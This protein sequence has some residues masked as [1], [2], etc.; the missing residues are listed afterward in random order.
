MNYFKKRKQLKKDIA[1]YA[2]TENGKTNYA[3]YVMTKQESFFYTIVGVLLFGLL[4][5]TFY[6]SIIAVA[7]TGVFG[8][9]FPDYMYKLLLNKRKANLNMQFKDLLY[10]I[11]SSLS[12]GRSVE[13]AFMEAP[14]DLEMLYPNP[15][16][17]IIKEL[18]YINSG[19]RLNETI[20]SLLYD[21]SQR[22]GDEDIKS[23]AD[24]F[25]SC[26][27]TGGNLIEV[28]RITSN[29]ISDKIEIKK[30]IASGLVEKKFEQKGMCALMLLVILGLSYM[31]G[32]YMDP[33]FT[34]VQGRIAMTFALLL[35]IASYFVG[36]R[37]TNIQ[38]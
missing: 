23:F 21:F 31:S 32:D 37:I 36:E 25:I 2:V 4:G 24:V 13:T 8:I 16:T 30:D 1:M 17:D 3:Y 5:F 19:L 7:I 22:S 20:E 28:V 9:F 10:S 15:E 18:E 11:S 27:R 6:R 29:I 26:K 38:V 34:T 14:K 35:L 12:A 33:M